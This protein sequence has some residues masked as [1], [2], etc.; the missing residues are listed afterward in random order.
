MK[1]RWNERPQ[2]MRGHKERRPEGIKA[3]R[4]KDKGNKRP[5]GIKARRN[6]GQKD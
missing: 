1:A 2:G 5:D 3:R 6:E 4:M